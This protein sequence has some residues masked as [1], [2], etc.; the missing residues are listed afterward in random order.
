MYHFN[1]R[2]GVRDGAAATLLAPT[3]ARPGGLVK[4][5][6]HAQVCFVSSIVMTLSSFFV[7]YTRFLVWSWRERFG[8]TV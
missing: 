1:I 4:L 5:Q 3:L 6:T 7:Q 8:V 2:N